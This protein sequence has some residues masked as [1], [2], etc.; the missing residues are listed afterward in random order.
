MTAQPVQQQ[1]AGPV[2]TTAA[3]VAGNTAMVLVLSHSW[4][5][6]TMTRLTGRK[7]QSLA[8][9]QVEGSRSTGL[10]DFDDASHFHDGGFLLPLRKI[11]GLLM[12]RVGASKPLP[13]IVKQS[14]LPM[15]VLPP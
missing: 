11:G 3:L 15:M 9:L 1:A 13:V 5:D 4:P 2:L 8:G 6:H 12:I 14:H 10:A 7:L